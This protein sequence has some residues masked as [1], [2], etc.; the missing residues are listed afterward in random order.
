MTET[1]NNQPE[2]ARKW[3]AQLKIAG[4]EMETWEQRADKVIERYRDEKDSETSG[5]TLNILWSNTETLQPG[6]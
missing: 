3:I 5:N 4:K 1:E 2:S 6:S